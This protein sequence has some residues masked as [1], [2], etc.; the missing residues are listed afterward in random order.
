M[1]A[2]V[3]RSDGV[4]GFLLL[5]MDIVTQSIACELYTYTYRRT[6]PHHPGLYSPSPSS[7]DLSAESRLPELNRE[8]GTEL[9]IV[10]I[11]EYKSSRTFK[12]PLFAAVMTDVCVAT[13]KV[14]RIICCFFYG[15]SELI[16]FYAIRNAHPALRC[17]YRRQ[18]GCIPVLN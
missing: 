12:A 3:R 13:V 17:P 16:R 15:A 10:N 18:P 2:K 4:N 11:S 9:I 5:I 6:I 8:S 7:Y 14:S 1:F